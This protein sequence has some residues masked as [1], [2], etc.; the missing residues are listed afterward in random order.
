MDADT[1]LLRVIHLLNHCPLTVGNH[2]ELLIHARQLFSRPE[3]APA[4]PARVTDLMAGGA[5]VRRQQIASHQTLAYQLVTEVCVL[6]HH[7]RDRFSC[8]DP[9]QC[10]DRLS[11]M[12]IA[13]MPVC[14]P[15]T[16]AQT[17]SLLKRCDSSNC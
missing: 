3:V 6:T 4:I 14:V 11:S 16:M 2:K 10:R 12:R 8:V 9:P 15:A 7:C 5:F 1:L 13:C 17:A